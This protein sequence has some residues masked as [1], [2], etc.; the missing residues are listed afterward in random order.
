MWELS[1]VLTIQANVDHIEGIL[2]VEVRNIW[3]FATNNFILVVTLCT[4]PIFV[5]LAFD[6]FLLFSYTR[7][8]CIFKTDRNTIDVI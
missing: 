2:V 5:A 3:D 6:L 8:L 1:E 7:S 4:N